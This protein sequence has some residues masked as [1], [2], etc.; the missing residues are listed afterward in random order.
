MRLLVSRRKDGSSGAK[1][2]AS[3]ALH[4]RGGGG[5]R[6]HLPA[7]I[8]RTRHRARGVGRSRP[9]FGRHPRDLQSSL[10]RTTAGPRATVR[11]PAAWSR[12]Y[13]LRWGS[14]QSPGWRQPVG[15]RARVREGP[16]PGAK[17]DQP[18]GCGTFCQQR[19]PRRAG[20]A[21]PRG[22]L[23]RPGRSAVSR[24]VLPPVLWHGGGCVAAAWLGD[25]GARRGR[26][27]EHLTV[28]GRI[29]GG[30]AGGRPGPGPSKGPC[31]ARGQKRLLSRPYLSDFG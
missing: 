5:G 30:G 11:D 8:T 13:E 18:A 6:A 27:C 14:E 9:R 28:G 20:R 22:S 16:G 31:L 15:S 12:G 1:P 3:V 7:G 10:R 21:R 4:V 17:G 24:A 25:P 19:A 29:R 23:R 2:H 26:E